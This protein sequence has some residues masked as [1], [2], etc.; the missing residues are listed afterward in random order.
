MDSEELKI[1][2]TDY[3]RFDR[4]Y[5][6]V[7]TEYRFFIGNKTF[8]AD[9]IIS[10][11]EETIECE[12]KVNKSDIYADKNNKKIKHE[13][14]EIGKSRHVPNKFYYALTPELY[15]DEIVTNYI[16]A[17]N[18]KYGIIL[19]EKYN[20]CYYV[21]VKKSAKDLHTRKPDAKINREI[22]KKVSA[23][24]ITLRKKLYKLTNKKAT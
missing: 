18:D 12:I 19:V 21:S 24:N 13:K 9:V 17:I 10:N 20:D 22:I 11:N 6:I 4:M 3:F 23:E 15:Y 8:Y 1:A 5:E 14:Y 2:V 7:S 16:E